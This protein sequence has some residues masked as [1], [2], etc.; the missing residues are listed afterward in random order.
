MHLARRFIGG[1]G[2]L[3][4]LAQPAA[5][6]AYRSAYDIYFGGLR[7]GAA[8]LVLT[9]EHNVYD[10][11]IDMKAQGIADLF[12]DFSAR[13]SMQGTIENGKLIPTRQNLAWSDGEKEKYAVL[14]YAAGT[15]TLYETNSDWVDNRDVE[16]PLSLEEVGPN[17]V[18]PITSMFSPLAASP[19]QKEQLLFDGLRLSS[20][21]PA[22]ATNMG[23]LTCALDWTPIAG[24]SK[25]STAH[26]RQMDPVRVTLTRVGDLFLAPHKVL[27]ETRYGTVAMLMRAPYTLASAQ[28]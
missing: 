20:I 10:I 1:M 25:E 26:A 2:L 24:H 5:A 22:A 4:L 17:T 27:V 9:L 15:P 16:V 12:T 11:N 19:C 6:T 28:D 8:D 14:H 13:A 3:F 23:G 21:R 7:I 18:D